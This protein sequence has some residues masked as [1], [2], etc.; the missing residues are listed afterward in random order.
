MAELE[1]F[2]FCYS[3]LTFIDD[4]SNLLCSMLPR[5]SNDIPLTWVNIRGCN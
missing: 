3:K 4:P 5:P 1:L 2:S